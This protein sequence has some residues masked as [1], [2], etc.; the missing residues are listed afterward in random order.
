MKVREIWDPKVPYTHNGLAESSGYCFY[1][2]YLSFEIDDRGIQGE[3]TSCAAT[4]VVGKR[5]RERG[6]THHGGVSIT[7]FAVEN[8]STSTSFS[9][10]IVSDMSGLSKLGAGLAVVFVVTLIALLAEL[11]YVL[12]RRRRQQ[13]RSGD[14]TLSSSSKELLYF[15][16]WKTQTRIEPA[17]APDSRPIGVTPDAPPEEMIDVLK[18]HGLQGPSR[19]LF[20]IKE[21]ER[22]DVESE[23]SVALEKQQKTKRVSLEE[24]FEVVVDPAV[25]VDGATP[26]STPCASPLYY[27]PSASP[28]RELENGGGN[29][30]NSPGNDSTYLLGG[31]LGKRESP[32]SSAPTQNTAS[33]V[34]LEVYGE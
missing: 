25:D 33:Y 3:S 17:R 21:E 32:D 13:S 8:K 10:H 26:F 11:F 15:F 20:T 29:L 1:M 19:V 7:S 4:A 31:D 22:E 24:C 23:R 28:A 30:T 9:L 14:D 18:W 34:S 12:W 27:T 16:C 2:E 6:T 5:N